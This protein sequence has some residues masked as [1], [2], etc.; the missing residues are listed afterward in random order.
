MMI[1]RESVDLAVRAILAELYGI[2]AMTIE[3]TSPN[4]ITQAVVLALTI[5][6]VVVI[7]T[8]KTTKTTS[9]MRFYENTTFKFMISIVPDKSVDPSGQRFW[10]A[11]WPGSAKCIAGVNI[12]VAGRQFT[13]QVLRWSWRG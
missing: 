7:A 1:E 10:V 12:P 4:L 3:R 5:F 8:T 6:A 2:D 9:G 11:M 13:F